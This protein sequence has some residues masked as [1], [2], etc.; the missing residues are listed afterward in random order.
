MQKLIQLFVAFC[1][2]TVLAQVVLFGMSVA[3]GNMSGD[4]IYKLLALT[5]G[6]DITGDELK[7]MLDD[8]HSTPNPKYEDVENERARV[9]KNL[10]MRERAIELATE[11]LQSRQTELQAEQASFD[12][13]TKDFYEMLEQKE[14]EMA[15]E[16]LR[17]VQITLE[18]LPAEQAKV[19]LLKM[20]EAGKVDD[21]VAILK[22]MTPD[23]RKKIVGEFTDP[24]KKEPDV[25]FEILTRIREGEPGMSA[26]RAAKGSAT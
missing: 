21:V 14:A 7:Q 12:R 16:G 9:D 11:Q 24:A 15:D 6:I 26:I 17:Q 13:R 18:T 8:F 25:L 10:V 19:Q 4:A 23:A 22:G 1:V 2:A 3:K 5:N 20:H